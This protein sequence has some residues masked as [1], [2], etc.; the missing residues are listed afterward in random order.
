[1]Q[2]SVDYGGVS[3]LTNDPGSAFGPREILVRGED[4]DAA[5]TL[6]DG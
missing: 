6:V 3:T 5:R 4:L 1:M 2:R